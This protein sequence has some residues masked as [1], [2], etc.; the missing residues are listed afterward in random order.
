MR[1]FTDDAK[2]EKIKERGLNELQI[3]ASTAGKTLCG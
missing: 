1:S 3:K 2:D